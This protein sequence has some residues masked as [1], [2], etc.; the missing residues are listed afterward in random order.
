MNI[1]LFDNVAYDYYRKVSPYRYSQFLTLVHEM[2][3]KGNEKVLDIGCGPGTLS[4]EAARR[5]PKGKL[6]GIDLSE[7]MISLARKLIARLNTENVEFMTGDGLSLKFE[8][9]SFDV[10]FSSN[11]FPWVGNQVKFL[12]EARRVLRPGGKLGIVSLSTAI[13]REFMDALKHVHSRNPDLLP[14]GTDTV[15]LMRFKTYGLHGLQRIISSS[16]FKIQRSFQLSTEEPIT[17]ANYLK[18]V[19]AILNENYLEHLGEAQKQRARN[20]IFLALARQNGVLKITESS[21]FVIACKPK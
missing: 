12:A 3:F 6:V 14:S 18:R 11:A 13:Y 1:H 20:E 15:K 16:G 7:N 19:N 5:I 21:V 4:T 2:K 9:N 17:P 10:V 8:D